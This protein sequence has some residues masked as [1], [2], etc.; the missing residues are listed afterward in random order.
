MKHIEVSIKLARQGVIK[1]LLKYLMIFHSVLQV[2]KLSAMLTLVKG[3]APYS[4][5]ICS[6]MA[7]RQDLSI[8]L[9]TPSAT[10]TVS[11]MK[12]QELDVCN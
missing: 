7:L 3:V 2:F 10:T 12:M 1:T 8:A 4:W 6:A 9:V 5:I 11:T